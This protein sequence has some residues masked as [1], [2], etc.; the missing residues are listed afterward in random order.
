M[1]GIRIAV[2]HWAPHAPLVL[3]KQL[4]FLNGADVEF[5]ISED[6]VE[7]EEQFRQ[8]IL[9][10][11]ATTLD[12]VPFLAQDMP[13]VRVFLKL[14]ESAGADAIVASQDIRQAADLRGR[15]VALEPPGTS[16]LLLMEYLQRAGLEYADVKVSEVTHDSTPDV[17]ARG[18]AAAIVTWE[19]YV[20]KALAS[21]SGSHVL[22]TSAET[23]GLI[24]EVLVTTLGAL[25]ERPEAFAL[26]ARA[27][28]RSLEYIRTGGEGATLRLAAAL[29]VSESDMLNML[30]S[31][32]LA[33]LEENRTAF[34]TTDGTSQLES[35]AER[36]ARLWLDQQLTERVSVP[37]VY[38]APVRTG[39]AG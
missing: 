7:K 35:L 29:G 22:M 18:E 11:L 19:P 8:G 5:V 32:T 10:V 25:E 2:K 31:V 14:G 17:L 20:Q 3:A 23:P 39:I 33:G 28:F 1:T 12:Y 26:L 21:V 6:E 36:L 13:T 34:G 9:E 37:M 4:G 30:G 15:I 16:Q 24:V 27:Q 38:G